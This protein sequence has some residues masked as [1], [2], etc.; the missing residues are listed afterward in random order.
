MSEIETSKPVRDWFH[1]PIQTTVA[2]FCLYW[3]WH[4]PAPNKAV[5]LLGG[6]AALMALVEMR[7]IHKAIYFALIVALMFVENRAIDK[8]RREFANAEASRRMDEN[9]QFSNIA[10]ALKQSMTNN[11]MA[12]DAT[13][14]KANQLL[15]L[16]RENVQTLTGAESYAYLAF[17]PGQG[18]LAFPHKG[19]YPLYGVSARIVELGKAGQNSDMGVT[20]F[21]GDI[22]QGHAAIQPLPPNFSPPGDRFDA[23]VFFT[24]RNGDWAQLIREV[25]VGGR[26]LRAIR[27]MGRFT[28]LKK[29]R[30]MCE[31]IDSNF[32]RGAKE[33]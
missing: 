16:S 15:G 21:L 2:A 22:V 25:R 11:Q 26:W 17:V 13:I 3:Y 8:D 12:F 19:Q 24:A 23:N 32:P 7:P 27:V 1:I 6:V 29:E 5:L 10:S 14:N 9:Q 31:I 30:I 20:V 18:F 28:S 4:A 33:K